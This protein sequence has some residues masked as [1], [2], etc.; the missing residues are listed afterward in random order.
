MGHIAKNFL[1][2]R[3]EYR[4]RNNKKHHAHVVEYDEPPTKLTKEEIEYHVLFST[5]SGSVSLGEGTW[6]IESGASKNMTG[7]R[8]I[9]F[10]LT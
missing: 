2:R 7:Q 1:A 10:S 9:L 8:D 5:L 6:L 3:E 4:K